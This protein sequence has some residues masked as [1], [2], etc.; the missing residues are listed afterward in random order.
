ME[1]ITI[2]QLY[3]ALGSAIKAGHG[4]K[5]CYLSTDDEGNDYHPMWFTV[6]TDP[7][8]VENCMACTCSGLPED[9]EN[10]AILG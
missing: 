6:T 10:I 7:A 1:I 2:N 9:Y 3:A 4:N 8:E 5:K